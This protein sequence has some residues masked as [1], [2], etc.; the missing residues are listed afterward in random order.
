LIAAVAPSERDVLAGWRER[1]V[2]IGGLTLMFGGGFIVISWLLAISLRARAIAQ[3]KLQRLAGTDALTGLS[4]RR[5]LDRRLDEEWRRARRADHPLSALF[6][7]VDYFKLYNDTY[8]HAMG[9]D[10]LV[11]VADC[12]QHSAKRPGDV[13]A[14]YGG[15]EFVVVLPGTSSDGAMRFAER[16]R[17]RVEALAI[18]NSGSPQGAL[19]L[20]IGCATAFPRQSEDVLA[21]LNRAD[22]AL[23]HAKRAGRNQTAHEDSAVNGE[24]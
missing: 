8:G 10:A 20:S 9:D 11:A 17:S 3:E 18:P 14:R 24:A 4:N 16:L 19:T 5:A 21:L 15:E 6:V 7:D 12:I 23:Y 2:I 13:V 1:S 22:A